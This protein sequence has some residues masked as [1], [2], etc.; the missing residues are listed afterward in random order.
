MVRADVREESLLLM[1]LHDRLAASD[2]LTAMLT[3]T[4]NNGTTVPGIWRWR[5]YASIEGT[6]KADVVLS[7]AGVTTVRSEYSTAKFP[8]VQVEVTVDAHRNPDGSPNPTDP[9][10]LTAFDRAL[11]VFTLV[12]QAAS[13]RP[14]ETRW[15][16]SH[17]VAVDMPDS[18][19]P[20]EAPGIQDGAY[21]LGYLGLSLA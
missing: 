1:D 6:G 10:G 13:M 3:A 19:T 14:G 15:G 4:A 11:L 16:D 9:D 20:Q 7:V 17:V 12:H 2:D 8:R 5:R 18:P 21:A